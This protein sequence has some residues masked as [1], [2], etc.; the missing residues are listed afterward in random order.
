MG[1]T[2][3]NTMMLQIVRVQACVRPGSGPWRQSRHQDCERLTSIH[4]AEQQ[5]DTSAHNLSRGRRNFR[6]K[7][8]MLGFKTWSIEERNPGRPRMK[9]SRSPLALH[10]MIECLLELIFFSLE[11]EHRPP[12]DWETDSCQCILPPL[13]LLLIDEENPTNALH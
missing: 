6:V 12:W 7:P 13:V 5:D 2:F 4:D 3:L 1:G 8:L 9:T 11:S 10:V